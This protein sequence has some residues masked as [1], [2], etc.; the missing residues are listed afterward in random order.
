M[1]EIIIIIISTI[2]ALLI[3]MFN[4]NINNMKINIFCSFLLG[5]L[6][7]GILFLNAYYGNNI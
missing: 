4:K 7:S 3:L 5:F 2:I 1:F 6:L